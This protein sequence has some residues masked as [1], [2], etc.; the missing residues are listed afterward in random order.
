VTE[1]QEPGTVLA[2]VW[3]LHR[4]AASRLRIEARNR[5]LLVRLNDDPPLEWTGDFLMP[6]GL[7]TEFDA[8]REGLYLRTEESE[9]HFLKIRIANRTGT[10]PTGVLLKGT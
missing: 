1:T 9:F 10:R 6:G 7:A 8:Q 4:Q 3:P 5:R 2:A